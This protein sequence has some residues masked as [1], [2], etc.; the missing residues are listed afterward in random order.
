[1]PLL[2]RFVLENAQGGDIVFHFLERCQ[3]GLAIGCDRGI[4]VRARRF[5]SGAT[6]TGIEESLCEGWADSP[7]GVRPI[8]Q[9]C[10]VRASEP[11]SGTQRDRGIVS[12]A[13]AADL[14]IGL[15]HS[16]LRSG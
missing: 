2:L 5:G 9:V 4:V 11:G 3:R 16:A 7:E 14:L 8:E 10:D 13:G 12:R 6:A 15:S 1:M